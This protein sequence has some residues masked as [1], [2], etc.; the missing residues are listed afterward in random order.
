MMNP[1]ETKVTVA[2]KMMPVEENGLGFQPAYLQT[3]NI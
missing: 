2:R 1:F 3:G